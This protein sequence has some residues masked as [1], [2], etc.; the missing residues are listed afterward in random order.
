MQILQEKFDEFRRK[1]D[2]GKDQFDRCESQAQELIKTHHPQAG[3]IQEKQESL[4]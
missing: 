1:A 4:K 3:S 2:S